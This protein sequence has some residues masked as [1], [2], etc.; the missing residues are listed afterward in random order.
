MLS[1]VLIVPV[2]FYSAALHAETKAGV[3]Q[4]VQN[5]V[6]SIING[7]QRPLTAGKDVFMDSQVRTEVDSETQLLLLDNTDFKI[8]PSS[9]VVID[10]FVFDPTKPKGEVVINVTRGVFR[11]VTGKQDF[12]QLQNHHTVGDDGC[13]WHLG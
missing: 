13:S 5:H 3:A 8:G 9:N 7:S 4:T 12:K 1:A 2:A 6:F 11:F 10:R